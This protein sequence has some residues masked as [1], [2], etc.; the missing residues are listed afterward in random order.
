METIKKLLTQNKTLK[1]AGMAGILVF[2]QSMGWWTVPDEVW[3]LLGIG[4]VAT[5]RLGVG[6]AEKK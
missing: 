5:L 2:V 1:L 6:K 4:G 3:A